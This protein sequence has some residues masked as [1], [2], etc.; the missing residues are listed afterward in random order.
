MTIKAVLFDLGNTLVY[1]EPLEPFQRI[2][3]AN[4]ITK[5]I[6]EIREAFERGNR[7]FDS[8]RL[9]VFPPHE[10]YVRWNMTIL[11]CLGITRSVRRLAAE[12]D[13]QWF[14]FSKIYVYPD[15]KDT[16]RRLKQMGLKLG[17]VTGGYELDIKQILPKANLDRFFDTCVGADTTGK[18]KPEPEAFK[19]ALR[20]LGVK[21]AEAIFVGDRLQEDYLGA[22][23]VGM[24]AVLIQ[25]DGARIAGVKTITSLKEIFAVF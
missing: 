10:F 17:V 18:R 21:P 22:R 9:F 15:V 19:H 3:Q 24:K 13:S 20:Q 7:E 2:L 25:R 11:K 12:I 1:Q 5:S 8:E 4:G 16:L 14:N 23:K 6:E